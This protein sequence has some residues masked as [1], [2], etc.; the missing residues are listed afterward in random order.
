MY[1]LKSF[2]LFS[3]DLLF[4]YFQIQTS[5]GQLSLYDCDGQP[6]RVTGLDPE[7]AIQITLQNQPKQVI[8]W[9]IWRY[10]A[11]LAIEFLAE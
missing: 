2:I 4:L 1:L 10:Y 5:V 7:N 8:V 11:Y 3:N 6:I 9:N